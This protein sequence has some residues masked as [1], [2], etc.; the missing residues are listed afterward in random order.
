MPYGFNDDKSMYDLDG[1]TDK[2]ATF[3]PNA[4][5]TNVDLSGVLCVKH[6]TAALLTGSMS[7]RSLTK[8][9][10]YQLGSLEGV[11][12]E[13]QTYSQ[14]WAMQDFVY[15][16]INVRV[17]TNGNVYFRP[18]AYVDAEPDATCAFSIMFRVS[19]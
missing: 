6:G 1:I 14:A 10:W 5:L 7:F 2:F 19:A 17:D 8:G 13:R 12:V 9:V 11:T 3:T 15:Y 4:A 18:A 16:G